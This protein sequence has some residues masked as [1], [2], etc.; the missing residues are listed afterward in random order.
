MNAENVL[1][2]DH[3]RMRHPS[4]NILS[5]LYPSLFEKTD[6]SKLVC[7]ACEFTKLTRSSYVSFGYKS[8][9]FELVCMNVQA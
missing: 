3:Q 5:R 2:L 7:D 1:M 6:K 9:H 8:Y 4:F